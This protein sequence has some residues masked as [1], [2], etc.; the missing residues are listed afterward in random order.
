MCSARFT[1]L[2]DAT[3]ALAIWAIV[4]VT[5]GKRAALAPA[6]ADNAQVLARMGPMNPRDNVSVFTRRPL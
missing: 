3:A 2:I 4:M 6:R 1:G 5:Y